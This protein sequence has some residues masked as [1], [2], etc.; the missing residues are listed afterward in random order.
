M[1]YALSKNEEFWAERINLFAALAPVTRLD[2]T[3]SPLF[4]YFAGLGNSLSSILSVFHVYD[5]LGQ[6]SNTGLRWICGPLP[7]VCSF[8]EGFL[9]TKNPNI[10]DDKRFQVYMGHFPAGASVK[11]I[12]HYSQEITSHYF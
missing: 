2:H 7:I 12:D 10:D 5:I 1:F 8:G 4:K 3:T 9:I 11:S 6:L